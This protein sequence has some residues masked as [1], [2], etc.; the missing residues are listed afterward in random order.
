MPHSARTGLKFSCIACN[1]KIKV[2]NITE[3]KRHL[4]DDLRPWQCLE[5]SC[6]YKAVFSNRVDWVIHLSLEHYSPEWEGFKCPL[7]RKN[8]GCGK[9]VIL[10]SLRNS[11]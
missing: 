6:R 5:P 1:R 2:Q 3:W 8:T 11:S 4:Y 10:K 9:L 7:C